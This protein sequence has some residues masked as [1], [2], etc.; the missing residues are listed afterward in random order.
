M[1]ISFKQILDNLYEEEKASDSYLKYI[2][3]NILD[4]LKKK[5]K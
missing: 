1:K 3:I 5:W 2:F 4:L